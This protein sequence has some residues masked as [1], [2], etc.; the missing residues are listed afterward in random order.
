MRYLTDYGTDR[1]AKA[2]LIS[3]IIPLVKR[4]DDNPDGVPEEAINE[5]MQAIQSDRVGFLEGFSKNYYGYESNKDRV[6]EA[7]LHYDWS[8]AS[9]ASPRATLKAAEAWAET[10][11]RPELKKR[12]RAHSDRTRRC[13]PECPHRHRRKSG[14][15]GHC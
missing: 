10:D 15:G 1:I 7:Q 3:S 9:Y 5:M 12:D 14:G 6:S 2:A 11:F 13:R 4:K 8:I